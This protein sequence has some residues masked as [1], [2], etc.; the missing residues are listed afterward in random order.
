MDHVCEEK[1][2]HGRQVPSVA[3][4]SA[5]KRA[6][7]EHKGY[8][9]SYIKSEGKIYVANPQQSAE[10]ESVS[11][12]GRSKSNKHAT[13]SCKVTCTLCSQMHFV[14][15]CRVFL[16]MSVSQRK[17][18]VQSASSCSNC[19]R[20]GHTLA[21][22][23][24]SFR[25]RICK[26]Q[27]N[28]LLHT[29]SLTV[30]VNKVVP[31]ESSSPQGLMMTSRLTLTGPKGHNVEV[32]AML[33][34][35]A[36]V[37]VL[38]KRVMKTLQLKPLDEWLTLNG[39]ESPE[40]STARPTAWV[41][42]SSPNREDWSQAVKV[43]VLPKVTADLPRHHLQAI[44]DMRYLQNLS[45]LADP[46][47]HEPKRVDLILDVDFLDS[48][49]LPEKVTG[50]PG[51]PSAWKTELGWGIMGRYL[52]NMLS[53]CSTASVNITT[54]VSSEIKLDK[55]LERFWTMEELAKGR[56]LLSP[57]E[58]AIQEHYNQTHYF[59]KAAGRYVVTLPKRETTLQLG[60][61]RQRAL[62]RFIRNEQSLLRKGNW[63]QF[64]AVVQEYL[65]LGHAQPVTQSEMGIPVTQSY[66]L[67]MHAVFKNSSTSTKLR[68]VFDAS[69][70]ITS[71]ASLN[72]VLAAGP[73]LHPNLDQIL[74]RF[75]S[76][77]VALSGDVAKMY[78]EVSLCK[79]DRQLHRFLWR[80]TTSQPIM[81]FCMN[82]VT[83]GVTSSPYV[84]VRTL[85]Q[86]ASDF[87]KPSSRAT[88]HIQNSFL[89][90]RPVGWSRGHRISTGVVSR[91]QKGAVAGGF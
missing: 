6:S 89:C 28:T 25:C 68:V 11:S 80:P 22:C 8:Q 57:Q 56:Q 26:L 91:S 77:R 71:G 30:A 39:I 58:T 35:G 33:D 46:L 21:D 32:T 3:V 31:G 81:D 64:Q 12:K 87:S 37:S 52:P 40:H 14:F 23:L 84:A 59:S 10:G 51:T 70:P 24:N 42:I 36:G 54:A 67:P 72:D 53:P 5:S 88:W 44:K 69:S 13:P 20:P 62:N 41:T 76:Y 86:T 83:F 27:H 85:Q 82:R 55:Q 65:T 90:R 79:E 43:T 19:L 18:H 74:I 61:S 7:K 38:S 2:N 47:F 66:Y 4:S 78:R 45:P 60:E 75:R 50:P 63:T 1:G 49:M 34:S 15:S 9:K 17:A 29:E 16:D 73:T 48:I